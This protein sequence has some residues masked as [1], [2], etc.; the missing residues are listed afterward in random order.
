MQ[1]MQRGLQM[2]NDS[3]AAFTAQNIL[4]QLKCELLEPLGAM[5]STTL[6]LTKRQREHIERW[7]MQ[8]LLALNEID[9]LLASTGYL[10]PQ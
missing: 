6:A 7:Q 2:V 4:Y 5:D 10:E 9:S 3:A 8:A 1:R